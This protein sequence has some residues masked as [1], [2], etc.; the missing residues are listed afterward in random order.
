MAWVWEHSQAKPMQ[1]LVLLAIADCANDSGA[2][3]YPATATLA[4]KTGLSER[5]VRGAVTD[6]VEIGEL[7]VEYKAGPRGC[8]RY[9][10]VMRN[11]ERS[12]GYPEHGAASDDTRQDVPRAPRAGSTRQDVPGTRHETTRNPAPR[13]PEPSEPSSTSLEP[14]SSVTPSAPRRRRAPEPRRDDVE[15]ICAHL[16]ERIAANGSRQPTITETWRHEARLL[17]DRDGRTAEQV[18]R[19]IDW[20]QTDPFWRSNVLS[21]PKLRAKYDQLRLAAQRAPNGRASPTARPS[22]T[23]ARVAQALAAGAAVQAQLN[24]KEITDGPR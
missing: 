22:T 5:G 9:R 7:R 18:M 24:R 23:D 21:M 13:A 2:D 1:R 17:L 19:A 16:A 10:V 14:S 3:A 11:P 20:C 8:N 6:L 12:A 4:R 15:Q